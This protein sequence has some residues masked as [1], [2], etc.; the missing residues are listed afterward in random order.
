M[1]YIGAIENKDLE[2]KI[3]VKEKDITKAASLLCK[4]L[5]KEYSPLGVLIGGSLGRF[6][7]R[8]GEIMPNSDIDIYVILKEAKGKVSYT[9]N[10]SWSVD[11]SLISSS[12][13]ERKVDEGESS[14]VSN[15]RKGFIFHDPHGILKDFKKKSKKRLKVSNRALTYWFLQENCGIKKRTNDVL[16]WI[17]KGDLKSAAYVLRVLVDDLVEV[18]LK[19]LDDAEYAHPKY[20]VS[21]IVNFPDSLNKTR[22][23]YML[24]MF[25]PPTKEFILRAVKAL[26]GPVREEILKFFHE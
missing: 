18:L 10:T 1:V 6:M 20:R 14:M 15:L 19:G 17:Q 9:L 22:E 4:E 24:A 7:S 11:V 13:L 16:D 26:R 8:G 25:S 3:R 23:I 5:V 21:K 12:Y 2:S